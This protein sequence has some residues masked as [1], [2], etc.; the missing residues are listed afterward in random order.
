[1][2]PSDRAEVVYGQTSGGRLVHILEVEREKG[3]V[4][5]DCVVLGGG[6]AKG[7]EVALS[8]IVDDR[9]NNLLQFVGSAPHDVL[10]ARLCLWARRIGDS[11]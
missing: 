2:P 5:P 7:R 4:D 11:R 6:Y 3:P 9:S 8:L 10:R 1:M